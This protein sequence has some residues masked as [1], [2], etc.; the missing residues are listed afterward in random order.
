MKLETDERNETA[1]GNPQEFTEMGSAAYLYSGLTS[2][3]LVL[4]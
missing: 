3:C 4:M 2:S 1:R